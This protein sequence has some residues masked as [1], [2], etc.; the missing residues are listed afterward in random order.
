MTDVEA[1]WAECWD[2][3]AQKTLERSPSFQPGDWTVTG[4]ASA[5][6]GGK[7]NLEWWADN[8]PSMVTAW[9]KW[10]DETRWH[11]LD[12]GGQPCLEVEL[13]FTLP[14]DI[15][16]KAYVDAI[17]VTPT[18]QVVVVDYKSGRI[19]D[20]AEQLGLYRVGLGLIHDLWPDW[21]YYWNPEKGA[22]PPLPLGQYTPEYFGTLFG[23]AIK[24]VN[25]GAFLP[26]PQMNC[27]QWCGVARYCAA[28][29]G[30]D[31]P[32]V[33]RLAAPSS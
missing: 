20:T 26:K 5:H 15:P 9:L 23:D 21:G 4:R 11:I 28:V 8:G 27:A 10:R 25:A 14:G 22:G 30:K 31:A 3:E 33:D 19:P 17:Y 7:R 13:N 1:L 12:I 16:V 29:G 6:Y 2:E 24:G 32:G 18:G